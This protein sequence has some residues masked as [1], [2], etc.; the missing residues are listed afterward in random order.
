MLLRYAALGK[1]NLDSVE[2]VFQNL[3]FSS[4]KGYS[5]RSGTSYQGEGSRFG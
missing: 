1:R 2:F 3:T 5:L 4:S